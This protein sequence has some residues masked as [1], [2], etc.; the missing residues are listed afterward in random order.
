MHSLFSTTTAIRFTS[1]RCSR[2]DRSCL[3]YR[4]QSHIWRAGDVFYVRRRALE[5]PVGP[6]R[7]MLSR[8]RPCL[9]RSLATVQCHLRSRQSVCEAIDDRRGA[10]SA[11]SQTDRVRRHSRGREEVLLHGHRGREG[12]RRSRPRDPPRR[13]HLHHGP[14]RLRQDHPLQY[15]RRHGQADL[16][17]RLHRPYRHLQARRLRTG[18]ASLQ[19][20]RL[21]LPAVQSRSRS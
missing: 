11:T 15:R 4:A 10:R 18:V 3:T 5:A 14:E 9:T 17:A 16:R 21:H 12:A 13:V 2:F 20:D 6:P 19:K 8:P 1:S 7:Q